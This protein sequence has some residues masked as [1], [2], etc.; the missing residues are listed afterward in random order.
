MASDMESLRQ[1]KDFA[2]DFRTPN[3]KQVV[4]RGVASRRAFMHTS[5]FIP[6]YLKHVNV[7]IGRAWPP[8]IGDLGFSR[9]IWPGAML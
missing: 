4:L 9:F 2:R 5:R 3:L 8:Q 6:Q 1:I 7:L